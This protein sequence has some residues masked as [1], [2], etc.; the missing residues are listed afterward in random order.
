MSGRNALIEGFELGKRKRWLGWLLLV[1][2]TRELRVDKVEGFC[3]GAENSGCFSISSAYR[4]C[5]NSFQSTDR[6]YLSLE[7]KLLCG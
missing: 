6:M 5:E 1:N 7:Q 4:C 3:W 2:N